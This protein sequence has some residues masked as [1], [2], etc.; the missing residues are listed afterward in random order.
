MFERCEKKEFQLV[1]H[2]WGLG[3]IQK[4]RKKLELCYVGII[5]S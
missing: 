1:I 3:A 2:K 4:M 5:M